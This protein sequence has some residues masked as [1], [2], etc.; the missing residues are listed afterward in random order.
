MAANEREINMED[1]K[2]YFSVKTQE[3]IDTIGVLAPSVSGLFEAPYWALFV[4]VSSIFLPATWIVI[5]IIR[6][7]RTVAP[8]H[9]KAVKEFVV[10]GEGPRFRKRDKIAFM[11]R[12]VFRNAKAVGSLIRGITK[13]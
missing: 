4:V 1:W 6:R 7:I 3:V 8:I 12:R 2:E 13:L 9:V 10:P 11:G 5:K